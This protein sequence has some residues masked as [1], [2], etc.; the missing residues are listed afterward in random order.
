MKY[1]YAVKYHGRIYPP[2]TE[3]AETVEPKKAESVED[4]PV[5]EKKTA[6]KGGAK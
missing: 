1:P 3:I 2:N 4:A 5:K 6:K